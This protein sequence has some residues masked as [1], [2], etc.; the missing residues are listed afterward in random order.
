M[1]VALVHDWLTGMRGGEKCLKAFV[2]MY[3]HADIFTLFHVPGSTHPLIEERVLKTSLLNKIPWS[4]KLY[5]LMLPLYP[6]ASKMLNIKGYDLVISLSHA[7]AKNVTVDS[8]SLHICYCFTPMRYIWDQAPV[9]FGKVY[10]LVAPLIKGLQHWD[11]HGAN[12]VNAFVAISQFVRRRIRQ[13]YQ[14]EATVIYPPVDTSWISPNVDR[15]SSAP[16]LCAGALVPYKR[17][18]IAIKAFNRLKLPLTIAGK[19]PEMSVLKRIAGET[20]T[21]KGHVSD[22]ELSTLYKTSKALIFPGVEDFGLIPVEFMSSGGA[23]IAYRDGGALEYVVEG[24]GGTGLL[25]REEGD[26]PQD[27]A[28]ERAIKK[29]EEGSVLFDGH[30]S[31]D[32]AQRFSTDQFKSS[33]KRYVS[34]LGVPS[35]TMCDENEFDESLK[36]QGVKAHA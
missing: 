1:K 34:S 17:I 36:A 16:Y 14:R 2:E 15:S 19:G 30:R 4:G 5:R 24:S 7:A 9:Y 22:E 21:F 11:A 26:E 35:L 18:E 20:I 8:S 32:N 23:V 25:Y 3:P 10:P 31:I 33:W 27:C 6:L 28:L 13:F 29:F 12:S